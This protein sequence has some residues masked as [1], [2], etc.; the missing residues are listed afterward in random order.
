MKYLIAA[1]LLAVSV[2]AAPMVTPA[3]A[4]GTIAQQCRLKHGIDSK[5]VTVDGQRQEAEKRIKECIRSGGK[6]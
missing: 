6:K 3:N 4:Q 1:T 2:A 5:R